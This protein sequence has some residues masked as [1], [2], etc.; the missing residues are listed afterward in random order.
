M[1]GF[2]HYIF[3][4]ECKQ[5][6][7]INEINHK[8]WIIMEKSVKIRS[9]HCTCMAGIGQSCNHVAAAMYRIEAARNGLTNSLSVPTQQINGFQTTRTFNP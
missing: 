3:N 8:L 5:S 6:Q 2:S 1:V 7:K 9:C 4:G